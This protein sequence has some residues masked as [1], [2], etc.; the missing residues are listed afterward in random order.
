MQA[1]VLFMRGIVAAK[2]VARRLTRR[3]SANVSLLFDDC[4]ADNST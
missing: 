4:M 2:E 1:F 3:R